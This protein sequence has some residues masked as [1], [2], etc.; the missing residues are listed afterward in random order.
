MLCRSYGSWALSPM[1]P[2]PHS[3]LTLVADEPGPAIRAVT[4]VQAGEAGS[5]IPAVIT[6][7]AAVW[8]KGVVQADWGTD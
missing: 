1:R 5:P 7:Q 4:A 3:S 8:A 6:S 2:R